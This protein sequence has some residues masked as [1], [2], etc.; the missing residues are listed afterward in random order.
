M[1]G[2]VEIRYCTRCRW[3]L[4]SAWVAQEL[5]GTFEREIGE[6]ALVPGDGGVFEVRV[7]GERVW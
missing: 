7:D 5:L 1:P 6:V 4:R 3:L 2:R